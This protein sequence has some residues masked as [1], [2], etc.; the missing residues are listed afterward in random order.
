MTSTDEV[1]DRVNICSIPTAMTT[2]YP[3]Y[4]LESRQE[5]MLVVQHLTDSYLVPLADQQF[6]RIRGSNDRCRI[7]AWTWASKGLDSIKFKNRRYAVSLEGH[8]PSRSFRRD[9]LWGWGWCRF[10]YLW[11]LRHFS[12]IDLGN[13]TLKLL[14][15][16]LLSS[17]LRLDE[18]EHLFNL[19]EYRMKSS[20]K[21][22]STI[23]GEGIKDI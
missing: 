17:R 7:S 8:F 1:H 23:I 19:I 21:I 4:R 13:I 9:L 5:R 6:I 2:I 3:G 20:W 15:S 16:N 14:S 12:S 10:L 22:G 11:D 18:R